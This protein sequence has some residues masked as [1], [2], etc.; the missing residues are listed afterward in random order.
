MHILQYKYAGMSVWWAKYID[1]VTRILFISVRRRHA[2]S[3]AVAVACV[4]RR[5][6][7]VCVWPP[8]DCVCVCV[9][10]HQNYFQH[11]KC[12]A[13]LSM[14]VD[15]CLCVRICARCC[16]FE[17]ADCFVVGVGAIVYHARTLLHRHGARPRTQYICIICHR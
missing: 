4:F 10:K 9:A 1:L 5:R 8:S 14:R 17:R 2:V 15:V 3:V 11:A 16:A 12:Q 6:V 13:N 7:R